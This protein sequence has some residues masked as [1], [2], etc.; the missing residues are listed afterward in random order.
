MR[1]LALGLVMVT[2]RKGY[3]FSRSAAALMEGGTDSLARLLSHEGL[4]SAALKV[5][6]R[7]AF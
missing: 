7:E 2:S 4:I 5:S 1:K 6:G 3:F